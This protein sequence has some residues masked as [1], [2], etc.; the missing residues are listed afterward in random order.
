MKIAAFQRKILSMP[1]RFLLLALLLSACS[2]TQIL[3][4]SAELKAD[5]ERATRDAE[6]AEPG[7]IYKNLVAIIPANENLV[8]KKNDKNHFILVVTWTSWDGYAEMI[9]QEMLLA[10]EVWV[11]VVPE[12]KNFCEQAKIRETEKNLR[13]EQLLGLPPENGKTKFVEM[14]VDPNDLFRP[15]PD[16]EISDHEAELDFPVSER[17]VTISAGHK[18]WF[19]ELK[20]NSYNENGY[21]WTRLGYTYDWGNPKSEIGLSEFVIRKGATVQVYSITPTAQYCQSR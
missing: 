2:S 4:S 19:N 5:Y 11:T 18:K 17:F 16:P 13:L 12:I 21:P 3:K 20:N 8:W 10:R 6:I 7:E 14:W 1:R 15:A 9:G